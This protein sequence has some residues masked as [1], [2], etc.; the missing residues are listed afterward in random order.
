MI[1]L[2]M[3]SLSIPQFFTTTLLQYPLIYGIMFIPIYL[4][5]KNQNISGKE[6]GINFSKIYIYIPV[7]LTIGYIAAIGEHRIISPIPLIAKL[8]FSDIALI[9]MVMFIFIGITEELIFRSILQT[10][11]EKTLGLRYGL[12]FSGMIF[13]I[14]HSSYGILNEILFASIFGIILGYIFQRTRNLLFV[15]SIHGTANVMLFGILPNMSMSIVASTQNFSA[16][17]IS[18]SGE[19]ISIFLIIILSVSLL[20]SDTKYW[21]GYISNILKTWSNPLLVT[22]VAIVIYKI[23]LVI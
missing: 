3:I 21:N 18:M 6:L 1:I 11:L 20:I 23:M 4:T 19:F 22:F 5:I 12:L 13:G 8:R 16:N 9:S 15:S 14:M 17:I 7:A 10:R 2:R